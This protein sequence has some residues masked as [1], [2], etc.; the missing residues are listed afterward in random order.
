[1]YSLTTTLTTTPISGAV[2]GLPEGKLSNEPGTA[3]SSETSP[4]KHTKSDA[5]VLPYRIL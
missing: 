4:A 1:M 5:I 2:P 3:L